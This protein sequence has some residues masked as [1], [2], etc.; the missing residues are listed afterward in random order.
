MQLLPHQKNIMIIFYRIALSAICVSTIGCSPQKSNIQVVIE[1]DHRLATSILDRGMKNN[2][3]LDDICDTYANNISQYVKQARQFEHEKLP[4]EFAIAYL[5]HLNAWE[6]EARVV[7]NHPYFGTFASNAAEGF[8]RGLMGD[9]SGGYFE[10][11]SA[12]SNWQSQVQNAEAQIANTWHDVE[13]IAI[14]HGVKL[15]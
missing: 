1:N 12:I 8:F 4:Q 11:E 7:A 14:Q 5:S 13:I 9:I 3:T 6:N 10:K 15:Q 2:M